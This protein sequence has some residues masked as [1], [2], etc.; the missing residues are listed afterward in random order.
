MPLLAAWIGGAGTGKTRHLMNTMDKALKTIGDPLQ[1]GFCS[2]TRAA[3]REAAE[4]AG[5]RFNV[6]PM[7]LERKGWFRTLHSVCYRQLG[8]G[9]ELLTDNA[10]SREWLKDALQQDSRG[11][12][13]D[14]ER[15]PSDAF[16]SSTMA[17]KALQLWGTA[18]NRMEPLKRT[19][20]E[21]DECDE[22]T[23]AYEDC[24][25]LVERYE[26]AKRLDGRVDF[27]DVVA[28]FAGVLCG[29]EGAE[30]C[31][32]DG[33]PPKLDAWIQDE[34]QDTSAIL[35]AAFQRL[36]GAE[37]CKYIYL[38]ADPWQSIFGWSGA[39]HNCFMRYLDRADKK[40]TMPKSWRCGPEILALGEEVLSE[41]SDYWDRKIQPADHKSEIDYLPWSDDAFNEIDPRQGWLVLARTNFQARRICKRLD[42]AGIPWV[43][44]KGGGRWAAPVRHEAIKAMLSIAAGAPID[45]WQ[46]QQCLKYV[47]TRANGERLLE[48]GT[49]TRFGELAQVDLQET[50]PWVMPDELHQLG[51]TPEFLDAV[52]KQRWTEWIDHADDYMAA[53]GQW[54]EE[55]VDKPGVRVSTI[56]GAKGLEAD[57]VW[58]L[59]TISKP[60]ALA[61]Q[62]DAGADESRRL[63]Y[64]AVTRARR[65]LVIVKERKARYRWKL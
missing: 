63:K 31:E 15:A 21:A 34:T 25:A 22:R 61:A 54:G 39:D 18:R 48:Q 43:P 50:W 65:R 64:V 46:W 16:E 1:V 26:Q 7:D 49:K 51:A 45:G 56:H 59:T 20:E 35:D 9:K 11:M 62:S 32:P 41:C 33:E 40:A 24:V 37:S 57:N 53:V 28:R 23:P 5:D 17:D 13:S 36:I 44:T 4:R 55:V 29:I 2:F 14:W 30:R 42:D 38:A 3:R 10:E 52:K 8:V 60:C 6:K 19:W 12:A 47:P 58:L 27:V